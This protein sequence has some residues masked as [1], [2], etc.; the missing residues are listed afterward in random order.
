VYDRFIRHL[1]YLLFAEEY[2]TPPPSPEKFGSE[3]RSSRGGD[4]DGDSDD[5]STPE[6]GPV[7]FIEG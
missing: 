1:I 3:L 5:M 7:V 6:E 2:F 4:D